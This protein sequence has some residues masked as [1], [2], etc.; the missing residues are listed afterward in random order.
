MALFPEIGDVFSGCKILACCGKGAFGVTY[1]AQN[2]LGKNIVIKIVTVS[3][4]SDRELSGLRNYMNVA[5]K[6]PNLLKI[7]HI[8]EYD[9][10]FYYTMEA[11]DNIAGESGEYLP[12]TLGNYFRQGKKFAPSE[13]LSIIRGVLEGVKVMHK[14]KLVHRDIKPDN[15]IF[16][17][18][19]AKLS[20]PGL[21]ITLGEDAS[22]AGTFG[23]IPPEAVEH[24]TLADHGFDLYAVGKVLYCMLT[25][26]SPRKYPELPM[27]LP[28]EV[29]RQFNGV[30]TRA[31][32][33]K[34]VRRF[35][36]VDE[37]IAA[38]PERIRKATWWERFYQKLSCSPFAFCSK[39][40]FLEI[41]VIMLIFGSM[42]G[43]VYRQS[44]LPVKILKN[45]DLELIYQKSE[46]EFAA[47]QLE[48]E[49]FQRYYAQ[50]GHL[51]ELQLQSMGE[52]GFYKS[53][54]KKRDLLFD[55]VEKQQIK[56]AR[57]Y[58]ADL[59]RYLQNCASIK[60][61]AL[62]NSKTD[63]PDFISV[64][65]HIFEVLCLSH[66]LLA[67]PLAD[68]LPQSDMQNF[69]NTLKRLEKKYYED[70]QGPRVGRDFDG[71]SYFEFQTVY[72]P[73]GA[74]R[75]Q[76]ND[77]IVAVPYCYWIGKYE[78][79][80]E[81]FTHQL[82]ISP[83]HSSHSNTPVERVAWND[84]LYY[85]YRL[86]MFLKNSNKLPPG[87]IVRVPTEAEWEFAAA[88]AWLG[89]DDLPFEERARFYA[90][91]Q[92]H[93]WQ[94]GSLAPNK[95]GIYDIYGNVAEIVQP[96]EAPAMQ[97]A[98][99]VRGG[100]Y[101]HNQK[102]CFARVEH[103]KYQTIPRNIGFRIAIAPGSMDYFDKKFFVGG[104]VQSSLRNKVYEL[105]GTNYGAFN[106]QHAQDVC[107]LLGGTLA[108]LE[109]ADHIKGLKAAM[110]LFGSWVTVIGGKNINGS[111]QWISSGKSIDFGRWRKQKQSNGTC[112]MLDG[113][114][115]VKAVEDT[116]SPIMLC[117]WDEEKYASRNEH[118]QSSDKLPL[119][120]L[121][122]SWNGR[123]FILINSAL[124]WYAAKRVCQLL[125]G[126]LAC[127]EDAELMQYAADKLKNYSDKRIL[128]G[129]Y[130]K[131]DRYFWVSGNELVGDFKPART[132]TIPTCNANFIVL[133][134]GK[135]FD[136]QFS[137]MFLCEFLPEKSSSR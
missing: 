1:L 129:A 71:N 21:V 87:Y 137:D 76:H 56:E 88:N 44:L 96:I 14:Y 35:K 125:N 25:G 45:D 86:T 68:F 16:V 119:E 58:L 46:R 38:L 131:R 31:C 40:I 127:L 136:S 52:D 4:H 27:E 54:C 36:N 32:N 39:L 42:G 135:Y 23:F 116:Q 50:K 69:Q 13:V 92:K 9:G 97:N 128:L 123:K 47:F 26:N 90:N 101:M 8:G 118:L 133:Q 120:V 110:P 115:F 106:W 113:E 108:E 112:L 124:S 59:K 67:A 99:I 105:I 117:Q 48:Y 61:K 134:D 18:G 37:F 15:I 95:L 49:K 7:Y 66:A 82:G 130:A 53:Y 111:W 98:V 77:R 102:N 30:L 78:V 74:H 100:S 64:S 2:P 28:L 80:H 20:D 104:A 122:F 93:S 51:L 29:G 79:T 55:A 57:T 114:S 6:H 10:G 62:N 22:F 24:E 103:L 121:R 60:M 91:S 89:K 132:M 3:T 33:Q 83:Q 63:F 5:G 81:L 72:V 43:W 19:I 85:C 17:N 126:R 11:A 109:D 94:I 41:I 107:K 73:G 84:I 12:A 65:G 70:W 75:M 34:P